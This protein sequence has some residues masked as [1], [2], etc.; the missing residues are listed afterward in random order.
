MSRKFCPHSHIKTVFIGLVTAIIL[1]VF[2]AVLFCHC[3]PC[4]AEI[5][6]SRV[7]VSAP[8]SVKSGACIDVH[9]RV[10]GD[11]IAGSE[12]SLF[13]VSNTQSS[14]VMQEIRTREVIGRASVNVSKRFEFDCLSPGSYAFVIPVSSYNGSAGAPLPD[15]V[16]CGSL[17]IDIAFQ[18]GDWKYAVGAFSINDSCRRV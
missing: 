18:G 13:A 12:V 4:E 16:E 15:E 7:P 17:F 3:F 11:I 9:G 6:P 1:F 8:A 10:L 14:L 2:V 5:Q